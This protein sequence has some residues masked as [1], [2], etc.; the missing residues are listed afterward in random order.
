MYCVFSFPNGNGKKLD[1]KAKK[2]IF[3][4]YTDSVQNYKVW[5]PAGQKSYT[6]HD[7]IFYE[8]DFI[9]KSAADNRS[10][11]EESINEEHNEVLFDTAG[12]EEIVQQEEPV[13]LSPTQLQLRRS[14]RNKRSS[15]LY[16][17]DEYVNK[18]RQRD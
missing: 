11:I 7:V 2:L 16:G 13:Q 5:D 4:G 17:I 18:A 14:E 6:R 3:I 1:K 12:Q 8:S 9:E 15:V 10:P